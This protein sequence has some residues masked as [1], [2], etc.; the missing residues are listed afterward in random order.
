MGGGGGGGGGGQNQVDALSE[1]QRQIISA[2]FNVQR[3]KRTVSADKFRQ[4][5]TVVGL[6][7]QKLREQVEGLLTRMNSE[8]IQQDPKFKSIADL[9]PQAVTAMKEAETKLSATAPDQALASENK[10]LTLLQKAEEEYETQVSVQQGGGGGG[11]GSSQQRE[12]ADIF[13]Q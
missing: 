11:G 4:N 7:Q 12:L 3:D 2:T 10:A 9:L 8:F 1:Q 5:S 13:E 6:S